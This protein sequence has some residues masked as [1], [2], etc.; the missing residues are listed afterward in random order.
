MVSRSATAVWNVATISSL[1]WIAFPKLA[2]VVWSWV[3]L[4]LPPEIQF[5][6]LVGKVVSQL[7]FFK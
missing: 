5:S 6:G 4:H 7:T 3:V 2:L 1:P